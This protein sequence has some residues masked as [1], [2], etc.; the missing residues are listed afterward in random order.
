M[1]RCFLVWDW[2]WVRSVPEFQG[3]G[4]GKIPKH[5]LMDGTFHCNVILCVSPGKEGCCK[6]HGI[7][8]MKTGAAFFKNGES[9]KECGFT[10]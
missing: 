9:M 7:R 3:K 8:K 4:V 6:T 5:N 2:E 10:E 1:A